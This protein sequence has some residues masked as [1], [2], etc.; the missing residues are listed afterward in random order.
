[1]IVAQPSRSRC[2]LALTIRTLLAV[3][4]LSSIVIVPGAVFAAT[5]KTVPQQMRTTV[6]GSTQLIVITGKKLGSTTGTL[7]LYNKKNGRWVQV[8]SAPA[9]FGK[10]GLVDGAKRKEGGLQTPTGIW[11]VGSFVFGTHASAKTKMPYRRVSPNSWW[12][13]VRNS[14]YN[15]W[16]ESKSKVAGERLKSSPVQYEYAFNTGYN[17]PPN[18]RVIGRGTAIFI[19]CFEPPGNAFGKYTYGCVAISRANMIKLFAT[20][21]PKRKP[22]CVIG[23]EAKG[24]ATSVY[25]Y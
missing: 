10:K 20:L 7:R 9:D 23:T 6:S 1:M 17:A 22:T 25:S 15:T 14:T 16:V 8:L 19:H 18:K 13:S 11:R 4:A 5:A 21:D 3:V 24:T 2:A 12:S